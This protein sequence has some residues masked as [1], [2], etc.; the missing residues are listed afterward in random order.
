MQRSTIPRYAS[1]YLRLGMI[2]TF[3][4]KKSAASSFLETEFPPCL[5]A[6]RPIMPIAAD[7]LSLFYQSFASSGLM[8]Q[9]G[10]VCTTPVAAFHH[11]A[12]WP[13][14]GGDMRRRKFRRTFKVHSDPS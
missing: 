1:G 3:T 2:C 14:R 12:G 13:P 4:I 6:A 7:R 5:M 10:L 11:N 8:L 9:S